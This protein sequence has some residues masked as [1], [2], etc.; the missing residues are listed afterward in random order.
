M[1]A[2]REPF[3]GVTS[4]YRSAASQQSFPRYIKAPLSNLWP[5][6]RVLRYATLHYA[7]RWPPFKHR[8]I[9]CGAARGQRVV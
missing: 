9:T 2:V 4:F 3:A 1:Q 8:L 7:T 5:A 6:R